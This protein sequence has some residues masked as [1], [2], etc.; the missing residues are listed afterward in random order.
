MECFTQDEDD[1]DLDRL[2][3]QDDVSYE[4][5]LEDPSMECFAPIGGDFDFSTILQ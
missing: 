1:L 2:I 3:G 5:S 4:P